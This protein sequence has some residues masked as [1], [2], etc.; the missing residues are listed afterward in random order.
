MKL[1]HKHLLIRAEVN[2]CPGESHLS[3]VLF[4]MKS[5]IKKI[6]MKLLHG[7]NISYID[8]PGNRGITCVALIETSHIVLHIWDEPDPGIFQLD[9]YSCK[10]FDIAIVVDC[11]KENFEIQKIHFKFLDRNNNL[12]LIDEN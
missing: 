11:L 6:D 7:P 3:K 1:D 8:Q 10:P 2:N 12:K 5:L 9:V 4:W